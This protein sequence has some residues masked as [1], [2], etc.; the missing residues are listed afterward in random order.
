MYDNRIR[1]GD[2]LRLSCNI[3]NQNLTWAQKQSYD[4]ICKYAINAWQ[5]IL[6]CHIDLIPLIR[7]RLN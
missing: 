2:L 1:Q 7:D 6:Y 5:D 3:Q 4:S